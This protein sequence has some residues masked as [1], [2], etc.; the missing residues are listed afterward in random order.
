MSPSTYKQPVFCSVLL[1]FLCCYYL[2]FIV[3]WCK[4]VIQT[5]SSKS[6]DYCYYLHA[7][8]ALKSLNWVYRREWAVS[9][10]TSEATIFNAVL[11]IHVHYCFLFSSVFSIAYIRV[12]YSAWSVTCWSCTW[13]CKG[14]VSWK[15]CQ[16]FAL[17]HY[18]LYMC[19]SVCMC[20]CLKMSCICSSVWT[21]KRDSSLYTCITAYEARHA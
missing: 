15:L 7:G 13:I 11:A 17:F 5:M 16:S 3:L 1:Q 12:H 6:L 8:N 10:S 18:S 21:S 14:I 4:Y 19:D 20:V 9:H 2:S